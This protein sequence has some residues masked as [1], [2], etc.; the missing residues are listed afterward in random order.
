MIDINLFDLFVRIGVKDEASD[1]VSEITNKLGNGLKTAAKVGLTAVGAA[2][3]GIATL[4][5]MAIKNFAEYEQLV[6]G[7][8]TLFKGASKKLQGYAANAFKTV[9]MSANDYMSNVTSFSAAL[10]NALGGDTELAA[11]KANKA[12]TIMSDNANKMGTDLQSVVDTFQSLSRGNF[13]MLDNLKLGYGGTKA[14]LERLLADAEAYKAAMGEIVDYDISNFA[15]IID[16]VGVIQDKLGITGATAQEASGTISGSFSMMKSAWKNL[17]T[18]I[19]ADD[20][21][22]DELVDNFV[23]SVD[24]VADNLLPRIE[25]AINGASKLISKLLPKILERIPQI[26]KDNLP[27]LLGAVG[28]IIQ[29]VLPVIRDSLP[30]LLDAVLMLVDMIIDNADEFI[31]A[32]VE[33]VLV[34]AEGLFNALPRLLDRIPE[35]CD[36]IITGIISGLTGLSPEVAGVFGDIGA[37]AL[38]QFTTPLKTI[39][40]FLSGDLAKAVQIG[41]E[42]FIGSVRNLF[43]II[44]G[45]FGTNLSKW[46]DDVYTFWLGVG[47]KL[48]ETMNAGQIEETELK[49]RTSSARQNTRLA[50]N[51]YMRQGYSPEEALEM[52]K[53]EHLKTS[54]ELYAWDKW[55][56]YDENEAYN[57]LYASGQIE[58]TDRSYFSN[59]FASETASAY[60]EPVNISVQ[61]RGGTE[62]G[63]AFI[64]DMNS[65]R[66]VDGSTIYA[67]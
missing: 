66:R 26:L 34:L 57:N 16:A 50:A 6:G 42:G 62:I 23:Y 61:L 31:D 41:G 51:E 33:I 18:G 17:V 19:A 64:S 35:L 14:E 2:A 49:T 22:F 47:A 43:G 45:I 28:D 5:G 1:K 15:D 3:T 8:D 9:G 10:I 39:Q 11:D 13:A 56:D 55:G 32:A 40:A 46:Y 58:G 54:E 21:D 52:A 27:V 20:L 7:V 4:S 48:Y 38:N 65:A 63:R 25:K 37:N 67:N 29:A 12:M 44:D 53:K 60:P 59:S 36:K 24:A 30:V